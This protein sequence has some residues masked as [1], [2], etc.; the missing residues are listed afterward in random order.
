MELMLGRMRVIFRESRSEGTQFA[1]FCQRCH[2]LMVFAV[3]SS[4]E[5]SRSL[6]ALRWLL[7][8][9]CCVD[10]VMSSVKLLCS[11][12]IGPLFFVPTYPT[13]YLQFV[14]G[15]AFR[16]T[17]SDGIE[18]AD[19]N[20]IRIRTRTRTRIR[21]RLWDTLTKKALNERH[22]SSHVSILIL[23]NLRQLLHRLTSIE[24]RHGANFHKDPRK[25]RDHLIPKTG[26]GPH[27]RWKINYNCRPDGLE[28][29]SLAEV[30]SGRAE[31]HHA[32]GGKR[33]H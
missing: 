7:F 1:L 16:E 6:K 3:G 13:P 2:E 27:C 18:R 12:L 32:H 30:P 9:T 26:R 31:G 17:E 29:R 21:I 24:A 28:G 20:R 23:Q 4:R 33:C 11:P 10:Y 22:L 14:R 25:G 8:F 19:R 15:C 5:R